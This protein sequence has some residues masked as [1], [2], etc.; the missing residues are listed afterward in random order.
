MPG[1]N[2]NFTGSNP[3]QA[4]AICTEF[5]NIMIRENFADREEI[6]RETAEF[7]GRQVDDAKHKLDDLDS[8]LAAFK[9]R[10]VGQ[11]PEDS[12]KNLQILM[13]LNSQLDSN[14]QTLNR[15]QQDKAYAESMLAQH[16]A[17]WQSSADDSADPKTLQK[18]MADLQ[19]QLL[20]LKARYTDDY[21]EV[22]KAKNDIKALQK[23]INEVSAAAAS[24]AAANEPRPVLPSRRRFNSFGCRSTS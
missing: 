9:G 8:K 24:P 19:S 1:F 12:E 22:I 14:T 11:L 18:Q 4:R 2:V 23:K 17:A 21:P 5:T 13:G 10:Y 20:Q 3:E 15:A 7:L 16:L 6:A